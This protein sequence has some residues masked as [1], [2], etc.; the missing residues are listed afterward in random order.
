MADQPL[1]SDDAIRSKMQEIMK[2]V[3]LETMSTK[4]FITV[5]SAQFGGVDLTSKKQFIK[6]S[7][8]EIIS[9]MMDQHSEGNEGE[10]EGEEEAAKPAKKK[11]GGGVGGLQAVR[12]ISDELAAF[13]NSEKHMARTEVVKGLWKY[14]KENDL[15]NPED[16]REILLDAKMQALFGTDR[17]DMFSM[18]KYVTTHIHPYPPLDLTPSTKNKKK[19]GVDGEGGPVKKKRKLGVKRAPGIQVPYRLSED[20]AVVCGK[21]ILPRPQV[22]A[23]LWA[24]IRDNN[25]QVRLV[26]GHMCISF[27]GL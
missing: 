26:I 11:G 7:I 24:Y 23:A 21:A 14:I 17:F 13:L 19:A 18:N 6:D 8:T 5:L 1:P 12:E 2:T 25:L 15:Q 22:T 4:Q 27:D 3:D 10:S 9:G 16:K 20:L